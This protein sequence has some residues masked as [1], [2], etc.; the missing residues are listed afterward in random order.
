MANIRDLLDQRC[1]L[2]DRSEQTI[3]GVI[4]TL[5]DQLHAV[6]PE[7]APDNLVERVIDGG[8]HTTCMGEGCAITHARCP[9]MKKTLLAAMRLTPTLD[10]KA[11]DGKQVVLVFLLV[12][13]QK[14]SSFH[15][16]IL[17]KLARLLHQSD[18]RE[19]LI[20]SKS[21]IDFHTLIADKE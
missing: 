21:S 12:G 10:L 19:A 17:S 16:R 7:Q 4:K 13:P 11:L 9:S 2:L 8:F 5:T 3:Q 15:L 18:L 20:T 1:I 6:H 14:S